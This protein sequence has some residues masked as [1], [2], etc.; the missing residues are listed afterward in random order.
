MAVDMNFTHKG[1][2]LRAWQWDNSVPAEWPAWVRLLPWTHAPEATL[3][4][5][6]GTDAQRLYVGW[7]LVQ[8]VKTGTYAV[9]PPEDFKKKYFPEGEATVA[10][11]PVAGYRPQNELAVALVNANKRMEEMA[12]RALDAL[13][14]DPNV[15]K[16][17]LAIGRTSIEQ[18]W[19]AV[20]R[21]IFKPERV[22]EID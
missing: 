11:L 6:H 1:K 16:R 20:N 18:G 13:A 4:F 7:F 17:W 9:A 22:R 14:E 8:N 5:G 19:M 2:T 15:D 3:L 10:G 12:L 21:A